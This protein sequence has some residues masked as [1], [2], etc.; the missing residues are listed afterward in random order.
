MIS[1]FH[2]ISHEKLFH[3]SDLIRFEKLYKISQSL[4]NYFMY[5]LL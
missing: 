5:K 1:G 4:L 3:Q 2:K